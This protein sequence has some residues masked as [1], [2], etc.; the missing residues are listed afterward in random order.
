MDFLTHEQIH[1]AI[2]AAFGM[3]LITL[4]IKKIDEDVLDLITPS[5]AELHRAIPC[6]R[7]ADGAVIVAVADLENLSV[8]DDLRYTLNVDVQGA[9][10]TDEQIESILEE[11]YRKKTE[12][13]DEL[14]HDL[15][16][17]KPEEINDEETAAATSTGPVVKLLEL[18]L[19]Q[20]VKDGASDVHFEPFEDTFKIRYRVDGSLY[21]LVPPPKHL[22]PALAS[23]IKVMSGLKIAERRLPQDGRITARIAGRTIDLRVSTLPTMFGESVVVRILDREAVKLD[24]DMLGLMSKDDCPLYVFNKMRGGT[25]ITQGHINHHP[26]HALALKER[27]VEVGLEAQVYAPAIGLKPPGEK[28]ELLIDFILRHLGGE[29]N[30]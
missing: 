14:I 17:L 21:E 10:T 7:Q 1:E 12:S 13:I 6:E 24:L 11:Y 27:A 29:G 25:P 8:I 20:A 18:V 23:R 19:V 30:G 2:A 3:Q 16:E 28:Y 15:A 22:A 5:A 9:L 4:D 26:L